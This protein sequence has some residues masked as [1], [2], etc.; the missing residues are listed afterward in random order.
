[1]RR[2]GL[3]RVLVNRL[4]QFDVLATSRPNWNRK[5][6][7]PTI[8]GLIVWLLTMPSVTSAQVG[9][10]IARVG[11]LSSL[12]ATPAEDL[13]ESPDS[14]VG[15]LKELGWI[16][17]QNIVFEPRL[18]AGQSDRLPTL[19]S[20][21][22]RSNVDLIVAF[23]NQE[24]LAA[25]QATGSIPIVMVLGM[26]PVEAGLVASLALVRAETLPERLSPRSLL[27]ST[28]SSFARLCR[29]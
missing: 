12:A 21:L 7:V 10:K 5:I 2:I 24:T 1:M 20:D 8:L 11:V 18:A 6:G 15:S 22:V 26:A 25:K 13:A 29:A 3:A 9:G 19:A 28:S 4:W 14:L 17:G 23:S 27:E 16:A